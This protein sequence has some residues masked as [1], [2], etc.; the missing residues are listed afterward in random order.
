MPLNP[1]ESRIYRA[2]LSLF[3]SHPFSILFGLLLGKPIG[4]FASIWLC[5]KA[6]KLDL[7]AG[8]RWVHIFGMSLLCGIGFT[9]SLFIGELAF[10][11]HSGFEMELKIGVLSASL[12]SAI[13]G[14]LVFI[15]IRPKMPQLQV[16]K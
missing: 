15:A 13:A 14:S 9:M 5:C 6:L 16:V 3:I 8:C 11:G 7:P 2:F 4:I 10:A 12:L 1:I